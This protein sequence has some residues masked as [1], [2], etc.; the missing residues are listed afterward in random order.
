M[1]VFVGDLTYVPLVSPKRGRILR[2]FCPP[3]VLSDQVTSE[4]SARKMAFAGLVA[5][6]DHRNEWTGSLLI[7]ARCSCSSHGLS[8]TLRTSDRYRKIRRK[9]QFLVFA[10]GGTKQHLFAGPVPWVSPD[11]GVDFDERECALTPDSAPAPTRRQAPAAPTCPYC[12]AE[13][14]PT[15]IRCPACGRVPRASSPGADPRAHLPK[16]EP[17]R[18]A[19]P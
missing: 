16:S 12:G 13:L 19:S 11:F 6:P 3:S 7:L 9:C 10:R 18:S 8:R 1:R 15:Q 17:K 4:Q 2:S 14:R 5:T